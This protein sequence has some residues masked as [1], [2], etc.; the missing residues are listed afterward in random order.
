MS[1]SNT[2]NF[3]IAAL[4]GLVVSAGCIGKKA[5]DQNIWNDAFKK[6]NKTGIIVP[7]TE[8]AINGDS[9][10]YS[11]IENGRDTI[12]SIDTRKNKDGT[13][14]AILRFFQNDKGYIATA[15]K[16]KT[17]VVDMKSFDHATGSILTKPNEMSAPVPI[18]AAYRLNR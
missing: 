1:V 7:V 2:K 9:L 8:E 10:T 14:V 18:N 3:F 12:G 5:A 16:G 11:L 15:G 4:A 17:L 13:Q 6:E